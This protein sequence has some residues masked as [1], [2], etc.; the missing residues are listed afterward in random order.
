[1]DQ[2]SVH[3]WAFLEEN[4]LAKKLPSLTVTETRHYWTFS[5]KEVLFRQKQ[6][7]IPSFRVTWQPFKNPFNTYDKNKPFV[8]PIRRLLWKKFPRRKTPLTMHDKMSQSWNGLTKVVLVQ[9]KKAV[10]S[11][12][13]RSTLWKNTFHN[14]IAKRGQTLSL[15]DKRSAKTTKQQV[16]SHIKNIECNYLT[17]GKRGDVYPFHRIVTSLALSDPYCEMTQKHVN[18]CFR[19]FML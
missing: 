10:Y 7:S 9:Q 17:E 12:A 16:I 3:F 14:T 6:L 18:C 2:S 15:F 11:L 1:M 5:P 13:G 8:R 4:F 19:F